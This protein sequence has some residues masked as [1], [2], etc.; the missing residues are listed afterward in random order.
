MQIDIEGH[1][2]TYNTSPNGWIIAR[3]GEEQEYKILYLL[4]A[5]RQ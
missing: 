5:L 4:L 1:T 3:G 2:D